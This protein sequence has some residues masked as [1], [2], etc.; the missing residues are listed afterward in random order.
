MPISSQFVSSRGTVVGKDHAVGLLGRTGRIT[1]N[2]VH[3][4]VMVNGEPSAPH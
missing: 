1:G 2:N 4:E 3:F